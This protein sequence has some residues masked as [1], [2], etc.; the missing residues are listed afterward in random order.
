MIETLSFSINIQYVITWFL[1]SWRNSFKH[2]VRLPT[3]SPLCHGLFA[4][5]VAY[6]DTIA[7]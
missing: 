1:S 3:F 4:P 7:L 5:Y 2:Y 6:L